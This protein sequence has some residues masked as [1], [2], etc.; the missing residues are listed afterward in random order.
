[1]AIRSARG[2]VWMPMV[3]GVLA[4]AAGTALAQPASDVA[5]IP[6]SAS[7]P[8]PA[9]AFAGLKARMF[10][11]VPLY[12]PLRAEHHAARN[13]LLIPAW[14]AEFPHSERSGS[15]FAW[16]VHLGD[17]F[18]II[19]F[20]TSV[21]DDR[22]EPGHWGFGIWTPVS[23]HMIEDFEDDSNPIVNTDYRFG[24]M[25]KF[26][27]GLAENRR[28]G[29]R[30]VP[31]A[32]E[33]THLG[34]EYVIIAQRP[35]LEPPFERINVSYEYQ[36]YG[37]S[38]EGQNLFS[39]DDEWTVRHGGI[40]PWG[41]DG[42]YSD[43]LLGSDAPVLTPSQK[44]YEPSFG[45]QYL[46]PLWGRRQVYLS[47]DLR[48]K[49]VYHYH[50]TPDNPERRQW[51]WNLQLGRTLERN[52]RKALKDYFVQIYRG[53]NPYGQLRSQA[54]YWSIGFGWVFEI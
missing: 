48:H 5:S 3:C 9:A 29:V 31:W 26:Q 12:D 49:L 27:Y 4:V 32:H 1:M 54:D 34:D 11:N 50:Q 6:P 47:F 38:L 23:F 16:Q 52:D 8:T 7:A 44:N 10:R 21:D 15:R 20:T 22:M 41:S 53:V 37:I 51:S 19:A 2:F 43:H 36:E 30:Y 42:Y 35:T 17:E 40:I 46:F 13:K 25:L 14:S 28:L 45:A 24:A 39:T 18:P 33:S